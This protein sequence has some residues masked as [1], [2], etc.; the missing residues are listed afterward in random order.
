MSSIKCQFNAQCKILNYAFRH[1]DFDIDL[2]F[3]FWNLSF[4]RQSSARPFSLDSLLSAFSKLFYSGGVGNG[5]KP[6]MHS[7]TE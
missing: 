6:R 1:L 7:L 5:T 3:G 4:N 2:V